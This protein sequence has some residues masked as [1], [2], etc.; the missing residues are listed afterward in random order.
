VFSYFA[1]KNDLSSC[2]RND[3]SPVPETAAGIVFSFFAAP[4]ANVQEMCSK[5]SKPSSPE[6]GFR[7]VHPL[8]CPPAEQ[9]R[10]D[11]PA[12]R[13]RGAPGILKRLKERKI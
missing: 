13:D 6:S 3:P 2:T 5:C 1:A 12:T 10:R 9:D 7:V 11:E 4:A 8:Q